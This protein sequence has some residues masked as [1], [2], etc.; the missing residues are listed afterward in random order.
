MFYYKYASLLLLFI[1]T[2]PSSKKKKNLLLYPYAN[3][4]EMGVFFK[5][6]D[7]IWARI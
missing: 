2:T 7:K 5:E 3:E 1:L 4:T 6:R